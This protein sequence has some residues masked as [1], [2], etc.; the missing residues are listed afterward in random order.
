M[1]SDSLG[2]K[3]WLSL[4]GICA[5]VGVG[6]MVIFLIFHHVWYA[7]GAFGAMIFLLVAVVLVAGLADKIRMRRMSTD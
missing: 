5:L 4:I 3:F 6:G 2:G 7:F 1:D